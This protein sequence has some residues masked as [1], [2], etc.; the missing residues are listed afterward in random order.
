[1]NSQIPVYLFTGFLE[2]GK[3]TFIKKKISDPEF[4]KN[5]RTL[6]LVCE[7]GFEEYDKSYEYM[8]IEYLES[9]DKISKEYFAQLSEKY[10]IERVLIEYHGMLKLEDLYKCLPV[11][12]LIYQQ[13]NLINSKTFINYNN[14][15]RPL[16]VEKIKDSEMCL[17]N[18]YKNTYDK[19]AF[20]KIVRNLT[21]KNEIYYIYTDNTVEKDEIIDPLPFDINK[22]IIDVDFKDYATWYQEIAEFPEKYNNKKVRTIFK[23][24]KD[25]KYGDYLIIGR[26]VM[27]CCAADIQFLGLV[28]KN[29]NNSGL[30]LNK[31]YN[32]TGK[33]QFDCDKYYIDIEEYKEIEAPNINDEVATFY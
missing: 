32:I 31:W 27:I 28:I 25:N 22:E 8:S 19:Q 1:M 12:W 14:M 29:Q 4:I 10:E 6:L 16:M 26:R 30:I 33:L 15:F 11:N 18:Y 23:V 3:T 13:I 7:D 21:K 2:S 17:F 20:H 5:K 9:E 24:S